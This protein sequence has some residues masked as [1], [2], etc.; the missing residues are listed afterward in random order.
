MDLRCTENCMNE[1]SQGENG[2]FCSTECVNSTQNAKKNEYCYE[3]QLTTEQTYI[4]ED[5]HKT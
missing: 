5:K 1:V 3:L 2:N 4:G